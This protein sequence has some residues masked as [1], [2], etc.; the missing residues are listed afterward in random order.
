MSEPARDAS[1]RLDRPPAEILSTPC[2]RVEYAALGEGPAVLCLH[3]AMGG[4][5]QSL[6]LASVLGEPG[7]RYLAVS[8]PGYLGTPAKSGRTP[9][10][11]ADLFAAL[12]DGLNIEH[13]AVMAVSGGGPAAIHFALR[14]RARCTALVLVSTPAQPTHTRPPL[15]F[16]LTMLLGRVPGMARAMQRK[17]AAD[18]VGAA[19]RSITDAVLLDR[20][21]RDD[22]TWS[23]MQELQSSTADQMPRRFA[24]TSIDIEVAATR[25]YPLEDI[26]VPTLL[27]HGTRD[28][29]VPFAAHAQLAAER[30]PGAELV[31][32]EGGEHAAIFTHRSEARARTTAFMR[33]HLARLPEAAA[34]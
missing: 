25:R 32:I 31:A 28:P 33:R 15:R 8:R 13:A 2:G 16:K 20:L 17:T 34:G 10:A 18:P 11:Q 3:G 19:R 14:H 29:M 30:I 22:E 21:M 12:L 6:I 7:Y 27:V 26:A 24:G 1:A 5:D 23:L 9:E 4:Y